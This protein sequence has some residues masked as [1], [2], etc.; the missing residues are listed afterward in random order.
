[1]SKFVDKLRSTTEGALQPMG[2]RPGRAVSKELSMLL[3]AT[4]PPGE[5]EAVA[6]IARDNIDAIMVRTGEDSDSLLDELGKIAGNTP[7]GVMSDAVS[8]EYLEKLLK[9]GCD[10]LAFKAESA[11]AVALE[12]EDMGKILV[13]EHSLPDSLMAVVGQLSVDAVLIANPVD[14]PLTI[15]HLMDYYRVAALT[16][17]PLLMEVSDDIDDADL[18]NLWDMGL[19]GAIVELKGEHAR[20]QI[21]RLKGII[22]NFPPAS[23]RGQQTMKVTLPQIGA[24]TASV[25]EEEEE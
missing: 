4:S 15:R 8:R 7:W 24:F 13:I 23:K 9:L 12:E 21:L 16:H 10:F 22:E 6:E 20:E 11:Q 2:F 5:V 19:D 25:E 17:K 3:I 14:S 1:M 18:R